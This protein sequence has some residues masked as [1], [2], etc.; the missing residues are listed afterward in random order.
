MWTRLFRLE[1]LRMMCRKLVE[2]STIIDSHGEK[3]KIKFVSREEYEENARKFLEIKGTKEEAE[4]IKT[5]KNDASKLVKAELELRGEDPTIQ[6]YVREVV[7]E[8]IK[9]RYEKEVQ[10]ISRV[11]TGKS[12]NKLL[13]S[14]SVLSGETSREENKKGNL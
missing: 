14:S 8:L 4:R 3:L 11:E 6:P 5:I 10:R 13:F 12:F 9:E 1:R 7:K 2:S